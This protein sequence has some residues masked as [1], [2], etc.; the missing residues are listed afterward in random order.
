MVTENKRY[1]QVYKEMHKNI[2]LEN[3]K[4]IDN[5]KDHKKNTI[6]NTHKSM[7]DKN[8]KKSNNSRINQCNVRALSISERKGKEKTYQFLNGLM[9]AD[10]NIN[11]QREKLI[12]ALYYLNQ[13]INS[14]ADLKIPENLL[15]DLGI[16]HNKNY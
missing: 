9:K 15:E 14:G 10:P 8:E 11:E 13:K 7:Q 2:Q 4:R 16:F 1:W 6:W 5:A 12:K 3:K